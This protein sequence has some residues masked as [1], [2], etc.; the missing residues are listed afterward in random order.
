MAGSGGRCLR[1]GSHIGKLVDHLF[2]YLDAHGAVVGE[3]G[4][5]ATGGGDVVRDQI[6]LSVSEEEGEVRRERQLGQVEADCHRL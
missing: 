1:C 5:D 6:R 3:Y 4:V 2:I